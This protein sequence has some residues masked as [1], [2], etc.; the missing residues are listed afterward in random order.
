MSGDALHGGRWPETMVGVILEFQNHI[1][2]GLMTDE[3]NRSA[4]SACDHSIDT[5]CDRAK[6][7]AGSDRAMVN[8]HVIW[9]MLGG[10]LPKL[11]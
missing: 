5:T 6:C 11:E 10:A 4:H 3:H 7:S 2:T 1:L 8:E 9:V